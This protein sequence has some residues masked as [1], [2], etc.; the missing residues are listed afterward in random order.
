MLGRERKDAV[1]LARRSRAGLE[2]QPH[3][4]KILVGV[5][6]P[7]AFFRQCQHEDIVRRRHSADQGRQMQPVRHLGQRFWRVGKAEHPHQA[8]GREHRQSMR[9]IAPERTERVRLG[10]LEL[11]DF[12]FILNV[13][14]KARQMV[15]PFLENRDLALVDGGFPELRQCVLG[16]IPERDPIGPDV[17]DKG[18]DGQVH[19]NAGFALDLCQRLELPQGR[20]I[21]VK[22]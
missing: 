7:N 10:A 21:D 13:T 18:R 4:R 11:S 2:L 20:N 22:H 14:L 5:D 15:E 17:V 19:G 1:L 12:V 8:G 9:L 16:E 3:R 6:Q